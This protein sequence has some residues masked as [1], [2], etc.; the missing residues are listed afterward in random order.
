[1]AWTQPLYRREQ[2]REAG[3]VLVADLRSPE[4]HELSLAITNNWRSAHGY[5]LNALQMNVRRIAR[6]FDDDPIV[7]QRIKRLSSIVGKLKRLNWLT[8]DEMQDLGGCRAVMSSVDA[9]EKVRDYCRDASRMNHR[10]LQEDDYLTHPKRSGYRGIHLIYAY[11]GESRSIYNGMKIEIQIRSQLQHSWAT[12]VETAGMFTAQALKSS[13]GDPEWLRF[14]ALMSSEIAVMEDRSIVPKMPK[15]ADERRREL[16]SLARRLEVVP[17]LHSYSVALESAE[18]TVTKATPYAVMEIA[19]T[20]GWVTIRPFA[21][22]ATAAETYDALERAAAEV[23]ETRDVVLV[24]ADS[25]EALRRAYPN[26]FAD[27]A[28]FTDAVTLAMA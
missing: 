13:A 20:E 3:S 23:D 2:I 9:V 6:K 21:N 1:M 8:L 22:Q 17:R 25:V 27:T 11:V 5:P 7:A 4:D 26:Y 18:R 19:P 12:A 24:R 14:F 15:D 28:I 16:R 10:L